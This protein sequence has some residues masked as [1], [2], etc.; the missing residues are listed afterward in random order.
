[1]QRGGE[2]EGGFKVIIWGAS[3]RGGGDQFLWGLVDRSI[4]HDHRL[5][6]LFERL[7]VI[8]MIVTS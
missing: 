8:L 5:P 7:R 6:V 2:G 1:M 4:H 3:H